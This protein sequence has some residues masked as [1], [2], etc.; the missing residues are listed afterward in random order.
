MRFFKNLR[1]NKHVR[2]VLIALPLIGLSFVLLSGQAEAANGYTEVKHSWETP[3]TCSTCGGDHLV[4][5]TC[6]TSGCSTC[7][8]DGVYYVCGNGSGSG[9]CSYSSPGTSTHKCPNNGGNYATTTKKTHTRSNYKNC[10]GCYASGTYK[11][12]NTRCTR[13]GCSYNYYAAHSIYPGGVCYT[14][15]NK[16]KITLNPNGGSGGTSAIWYY[17]NT[18]KYYSNEACS[19]QISNITQPTR[20]GHTFVHYYGDG[21]CGG[22]S[23][24]R[25]IVPGAYSGS[26]FA[27]DLCTDIYQNATLYASWSANTYTISYNANGGS[28]APSAHSYT[29]AASGTTNLS[30]TVPTR[31]GYKFLGWSLNSNAT[32]ASYSAGQAWGLNNASNYTL[33]AVWQKDAFTVTNWHGKHQNG[34]WVAITTTS[35]SV[36]QGASYTPQYTTVPFGYY[37]ASYNYWTE[38]YGTHL[39]SGTPGVDAFTMPSSN[40]IIE[41]Y[42]YPNT[43]SITY[44][45]NGGNGGPGTENFVYDTGY[46]VST[47]KPTRPGYTF[48]GWLDKY[49][50]SSTIFSG[51]EAYP[52]GWGSNTLVAQWTPKK[53]QITFDGNGGTVGTKNLWYYFDTNKYYSDAACTKQITSIT[54]PTRTGYTFIH[55]Y[56]NG[57]SGGENEERYVYDNGGT[58][59]SDLCTDIYGD[60]TLYAKWERNQYTVTYDAN[61]GT[62]DG[63]ATASVYYD[64]DIDLGRT[65]AKN[66]RIFLGWAESKDA[67]I[68]LSN[69][70][71]GTSNVTLYAIYS[72][73]VSDVKEAYLVAW[74]KKGN[75]NE[76]R[77]DLEGAI[78]NGYL[79]SKSNVN[80]LSGLSYSATSEVSVAIVLY[81]HAGNKTEIPVVLENT[82]PTPTPSPMPNKY[83]QTV[84]HWTWN[85]E[86]EQWIYLTAT[87]KLVEENQTFTPEYLP[88]DDPAYPKGFYNYQIDAPYKVTAMKEVNAYYKPIAYKLYFDPNGGNCDTEYKTVYNGGYIG[89]L[90][91]A[92]REGY[93]FLGWFTDKSGGTQIFDGDKYDKMGDTTVY[94]HWQIHT[95]KV[96]YDYKTNLGTSADFTEAEVTYG[97]SVD[98]TNKAYKEG[99]EFVGWN[100]D[101]DA[102]TGLT[103]YKM[104]DKNLYLYAIYKK[105]ITATFIDK[106][107]SKV[108]TRKTE[109]TIYNK[110]LSVE[111][112]VPE[113]N[114]MTGWECLGWS[115][116]TVGKAAIEAASGATL[117]LTEDITL[118]GCYVREITV[119]YDTNGSET[120][121]PDDTKEQFFNAAGNYENPTFKLSDA[122][123][124]EKHSFVEW[125]VTKGK[126]VGTGHEAGRE[127]AFEQD[128]TLKARWD[129]FPEI[130][131]YDRYFTLEEAVGGQITP[132]R[133]FEKV[134][135]TDRE[136]GILDNGTDVTIPAYSP[137]EFKSFTDDGSVTVTYKATD[138]FGNETTKTVTVFIVDTDDI[139]ALFKTYLRFIDREYYKNA[140]NT[141]VEKE[142]G[143]LEEHSKWKTDEAY[144][145]ALD[146]VLSYEKVGMVTHKVTVLGEERVVPDLST[147]EW[148][149]QK[150]TWTLNGTNLDEVKQFVEHEGFAKY[151]NADALEDFYALFSLCNVENENWNP[152]EYRV[153]YDANGGSGS[154]EK[155]IF[156]FDAEGTLRANVFTR[157][158]HTFAGWNTKD[159]GTGESYADGQVVKNLTNENAVVLY[160]IWTPRTYTIHY[161]ANGGTGTTAPSTHTYGVAKALAA[162]GF[163]K[164]DYIFKGWN[165]KADGT[166]FGYAE[167]AV[168]K[169]LTSESSMTLYAQWT[170]AQENLTVKH[171]FE[172]REVAASEA[173]K[174]GTFDVYLN[175]KLDMNDV[176][177]YD[178]PVDY[179]MTYEVKDIKAK[180]GYAYAGNSSYSGV[181]SGGSRT[182]TL[183]WET[184]SYT[185]TFDG[186]GGTPS[187]QTRKVKSGSPYGTLPT[188]ERVGYVFKGWNLKANGGGEAVT[189]ET[190]MTSYDVTIYAQWEECKDAKYVV[191]HYQM[192]MEGKYPAAPFETEEFKGLANDTVTP[193]VKKYEG[194]T[195]P[196]EQTLKIGTDGSAVLEYR[197]ERNKYRLNMNIIIDG[198]HYTGDKAKAMGGY[199]AV[200]KVNGKA[201][202]PAEASVTSE[203]Y[204]IDIYEPLYYG[205]TYEISGIG[206]R[207]G[208]T[209]LGESSY[210]GTIKSDVSV[211]L[212]W[213]TNAYTLTFD[214]NGGTPAESSRRV[215]YNAAYG[216]LPGA[217]RTG[218]TFAGWN[219]KADGSGTQVTAS[220]LMGAANT[221]IYAQWTINQYTATFDANGGTSANPGTI[222]KN[223][224]SEL[225]TLPTTSRTGYTFNGWYTAKSGGSKISATTKLTGNVT[226][227]AQWTINQYTATFDANGGSAANPGTIKKNY[228]SELGT[229][230]T[231]SRTGHT[232][233]GWYTAK[234]GGSKI[235]TT[236]K[237]TGNVT[238]YARWTA[239]TYK[240]TYNA[241]GGSGAPSATTYTYASSG[242]TKLS[243]TKPTKSGYTFLGWSL[244]SSASS[245]SYSAGQNWSLSNASNYTLYAV[246][247][248]PNTITINYYSNY[249]DYM[250]NDLGYGTGVS[251]GTNKLILSQTLGY[252]TSYPDGLPNIQ[253]R[254]YLYLS[255]TG[256]QPT[257]YWGT[258]SSGGSLLHVDT[259][260]T[261][262]DLA[263]MLGASIDNGSRSVNVYVQWTDIVKITLDKQW[264]YGGPD[265]I[266]FRINKNVYYTDPACT[267]VVTQITTPTNPGYTFQNY[268]YTW[269]DGVTER[270]IYQNGTFA[271][272]LCTDL[273]WNATLRA[274][275]L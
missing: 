82:N 79:Y 212:S 121:I 267:N 268:Y 185:L 249:A 24:E 263:R 19:T 188:A 61:G 157:T 12:K 236:T 170:K 272:D 97:G 149:S 105:N 106:N 136:D 9:K 89:E 230:P 128:T 255:R 88:A 140:D 145:A 257:H 234:S 93:D 243:S 193:K 204:Y 110:T 161:D 122:P 125:E 167:G 116:E 92:K 69:K 16:I 222:K 119:T 233:D 227:Y 117:T 70:K 25:Y 162:N 29:Y 228:N 32:S 22:N 174:Y 56:G 112:K 66:G 53:I 35:A 137:E 27:S 241:N 10:S 221:T 114:K 202:A 229:L 182:V 28:G 38:G 120:E 238:Y 51:G 190:R 75:K 245:A 191:K 115:K 172:G 261:G 100:T 55:Y 64:E 50:G 209:Y 220:T 68:C 189:S 135:A 31:A 21:S 196:A 260:G 103:S 244:S 192:D 129:Q 197:Y 101:P 266:Y 142:N 254:D 146:N 274:Y 67:T 141:Y 46:H 111:V 151:L 169:N 242:T 54:P 248:G 87:D 150:Q 153:F 95:N 223:Y 147:G 84:R 134:T 251:S 225:G 270:Y 237:L 194:F 271:S 210:Q 205:A 85:I 269:N 80:L 183:K 96:I 127:V 81:D 216:T 224:N 156:R 253:N 58:I 181:I 8:G 168:L 201:Y 44:D 5:G 108:V 217:S 18:N 76:N 33:Y 65:A 30:S 163:T 48:T 123:V 39:G 7:G 195:S 235:S 139:D 107:D 231:T 226:Y 171:T 130:E 94:A 144:A 57:S 40:V 62:L 37:G 63:D 143:G 262:G 86:T 45:A 2:S 180:A 155:S 71:M 131:A 256:Y 126:D 26:D 199:A 11:G 213:K 152:Y 165:T 42:Y 154:M 47:T 14:T 124:L 179:G 118:Y 177:V 49:S 203:G 264:G 104:P 77:M 43:Y 102:T 36:S 208:Y 275:Y 74:D 239:N 1:K 41:T 91:T 250:A 173:S 90:P 133:L 206:T 3:S 258:S 218:H 6:S 176:S 164:A 83:L 207:T 215:N 200:M 232:F 219:T 109:N 240:I 186:N 175:G 73:P 72:L 98:L 158:G 148:V 273:T 259:G 23:G 198:T 13:S 160:A 52:S 4:S 34:A 20:T 252:F 178:A 166:G 78:T 59:A 184:G 132:E 138:S 17:Y 15:A 99:W 187:E 247:S 265:A 159:D 60:A 246:W 113:Q 214:G 211:D